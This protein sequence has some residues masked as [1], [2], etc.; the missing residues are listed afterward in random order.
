MEGLSLPKA[1]L[2]YAS[3][4]IP[5]CT[6]SEFPKLWATIRRALVPGGHFAGQLFGNRDE[7]AGERPM[8]FLSRQ[9]AHAMT[10]GYR[11]EL[12]RETEEEGQSYSGPKHWHFF[13]MILEKRRPGS[14][15]SDGHR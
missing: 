14:S 1:D 8:T 11:V 12:F 4:S 2:V 15:G 10:R 6:P 7:W 3:Y 9:Q 5:F 13:D